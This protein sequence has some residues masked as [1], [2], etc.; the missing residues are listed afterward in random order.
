MKHISGK[1]LV[2]GT[3]MM[4][5]TFTSTGATLNTMDE[6]GAAI[7]QCWKPPADPKDASV[8]LSFSFRRDGTLIGPPKPTNI[9]VAGDD[10]VRKAFIDAAI[11]AVQSCA[12][13][14]FSPE[15]ADGIG[16][17]VFTVPFASDR[18]DG[19]SVTAQ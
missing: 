4:A 9:K 1:L 5:A 8:T 7:Q 13:L 16:G 19:A 6:V 3:I 12:P 10:K 14:T 2:A 17:Q 11:S 15:L 18:G